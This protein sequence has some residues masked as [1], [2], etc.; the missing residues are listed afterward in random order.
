MINLKP[1]NTFRVLSRNINTLST[2]LDYVQWKAASHTINS[3]KADAASFQEPNVAWNKQHKHRICQIM[4]HP[5]GHAII[6]TMISTEVNTGPTQH[7]GTLQA[8]MGDWVSHSV[9]TRQDKT[10]LG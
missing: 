6:S 8:I 10:G 4:Q 5:T 2:Q 7:G 3:S 1:F 9:G